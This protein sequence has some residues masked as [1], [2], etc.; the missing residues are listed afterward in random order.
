MLHEEK[1]ATSK[2]NKFSLSFLVKTCCNFAA[3]HLSLIY[4]LFFTAI[5]P[6]LFIEYMMDLTLYISFLLVEVK[7][8]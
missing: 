3:I 7:Q 6:L 5:S 1:R 8:L 2:N 4:I